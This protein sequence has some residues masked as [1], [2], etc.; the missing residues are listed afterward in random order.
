MATATKADGEE[1]EFAM[2]LEGAEALDDNM[3]VIH[4]GENQV[5]CDLLAVGR[6]LVHLLSHKSV[7]RLGLHVCLLSVLL[8]LY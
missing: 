7:F 5:T 3:F 2:E 8:C 6:A 1:P 4:S